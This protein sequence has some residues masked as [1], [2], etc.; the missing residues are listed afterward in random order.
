[1]HYPGQKK[2]TIIEIRGEKN[3]VPRVISCSIRRDQPRASPSRDCPRLLPCADRAWS[4]M[5][6]HV[7]QRSSRR[8][9]RWWFFFFLSRVVFAL[10]LYVS[11]I[12]S[13]H[14]PTTT[15]S[16][17][18]ASVFLDSLLCK[19]IIRCHMCPCGRLL[20]GYNTQFSSRGVVVVRARRLFPSTISGVRGSVPVLPLGRKLD[21][22]PV[23]SC[24][25][26]DPHLAV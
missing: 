13:H 5:I 19:H 25:P 15:W 24:A 7:E 21:W 6:S 12:Q 14:F 26:K 22:Q 23:L 9:S 4:N 8:E 16:P 20:P 10:H 1:M 2:R 11:Y 17:D 18:R 3:A